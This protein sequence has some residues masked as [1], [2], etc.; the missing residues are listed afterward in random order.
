[1]YTYNY[2]EQGVI[3]VLKCLYTVDITYFLALIHRPLSGLSIVIQS[4][5][6]NVILHTLKQ[7]LTNHDLVKYCERLL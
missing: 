1:M 5:Y 7:I 6:V 4:L 2:I 3:F